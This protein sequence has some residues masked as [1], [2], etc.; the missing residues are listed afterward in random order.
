MQTDSFKP[1]IVTYDQGI[2]QMTWTGAIEALRRGHLLPKA[3][4]ADVFLG[5]GT[6]TMMS[7]AAYIEGLGYGAKTFTVMD[8]N[9]ARGL[10]TVQGAMAVFDSDT[11]AL[12]AIVD[13]RLV[14]EFKTA[15]DSVLGATLLAR[16]DSRT[17]LVVGAGAVAANLVAAYS[18]AFPGL[19][20]VLIWA[21]RP[22]QAFA[23]AGRMDGAISVRPAPDLR[24]AMAKAD[25]ITS[26]TMARAP[27]ILGEWVQPG[28]HVDLIGAYKA[29]MRE[30]D[31]ALL[32]T[33]SLFV[34]SRET[35]LGHIGE[36]MIPIASGVI[37]AEC[38]LGD[39]YN[40]VQPQ[41]RRRTSRDEVTVYKNGGG[42][43]M[44]LMIASS[45]ATNS[46]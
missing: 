34:D 19:R 2:G 3:Q 22:E 38:V 1:R 30:G 8:A 7:R 16:Q 43:H 4:I 29:D 5:P 28:T 14:T 17:L 41:A 39:L 9:A 27:V 15:A 44:D 46:A 25:I 20:E 21:R 24:A 13:C 36:L 35:T 45:I 40:L 11:G 32:A 42:A 6:G 37:T 18:A 26:A 23:L 31:D 12:T 33:S 10:P